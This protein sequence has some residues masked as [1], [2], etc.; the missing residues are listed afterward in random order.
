[1]TAAVEASKAALRV[2]ARARRRELVRRRPEA[3]WQAG[4]RAPDMLAAL[5]ITRPG[6]VAAYRAL[7]SE[8]DPRPLMDV[9]AGLGWTIALPV[10]EAPDAPVVFRVWKPGDKLAPDA[11]GILAPLNSAPP[12][13]P[14]IIIA[15]VL[16]FDSTGRRLGQGAGY[17]DRTLV[18]LRSQRPRP[19]VGLAFAEQEV[20]FVPAEPHDQKLDAVLT[21]KGYRPLP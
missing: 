1:M 21:E 20:E 10:C 4:D 11:V 7:G 14:D 13:D 5:E 18:L 9:M 2:Q 3:D 17:Y 8:M 12:A 16:A 19:F 6:V 15:P